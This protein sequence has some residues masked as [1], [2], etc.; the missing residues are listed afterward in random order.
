LPLCPKAGPR[1]LQKF[2]GERDLEIRVIAA[3]LEEMERGAAAEAA[4]DQSP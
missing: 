1:A 3:E 4:S 2:R